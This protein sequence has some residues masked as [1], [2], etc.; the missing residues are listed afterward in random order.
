ML[1]FSRWNDSPCNDI[2]STASNYGQYLNIYEHIHSVA[3]SSIKLELNM[4]QIV[5]GG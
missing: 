3:I 4:Q 2:L 1:D 5:D